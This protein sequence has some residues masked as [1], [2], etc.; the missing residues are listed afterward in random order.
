MNRRTLITQVQRFASLRGQQRSDAITNRL[1]ETPRCPV[2]RYLAACEAFDRGDPAPGV[3]HMMIAYH[4]EPDIQSASLL[5]FAGLNWVSR[6]R[7]AVLPVLLETWEEF[8]R[9][10]FDVT[11]AERLL[12][13]AFAEPAPEP[14]IGA[15]GDLARRLWRLPIRMLRIQIRE[16]VTTRNL[17]LCPTL[18][19]PA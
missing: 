9:P 8:R 18:L 7:A 11:F 2:A 10:Q 6:P 3:R 1:D 17:E 4:A 16:A 5:A 13:G 19:S 14:D 15:A 12:L